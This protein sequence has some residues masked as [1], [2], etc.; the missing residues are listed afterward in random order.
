MGRLPWQRCRRQHEQNSEEKMFFKQ[1]TPQKPFK[2]CPEDEEREGSGQSLKENEEE[3][4]RPV[5][6][7]SLTSYS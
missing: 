7:R 2:L 1:K 3:K 5:D 6:V 4:E